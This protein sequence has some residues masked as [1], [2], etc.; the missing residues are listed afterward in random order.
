MKNF[1]NTY[2]FVFSAIMVILVAAVLSS[3]T[4]LL[5]PKQQ[6]NIEIEKKRK[7][8]ASIEVE[9]TTK[10]AEELYGKYIK[11]AYVVDINGERIEGVDAFGL[12]MKDEMRKPEEKRELPVY[13]GVLDEGK[14]EFIVPVRGTGLWGPI[15]G[16]VS[17]NDDF[18]TIFGTNFDHD[19]ETPGLGA[20]ITTQW[21]QDEFKGKKIF[22]EDGTFTSVKV[23]KG[24]VDPNSNNQVDAISG[25][26]LTSKGLENM[27]YDCLNLYQAYFKKQL[28]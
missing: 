1:S 27:L 10:N 24:K 7:I 8:L 21:F 4:I 6:K 15:F 9:S 22:S 14:K 18:N 2:I 5:Q 11:E 23:V 16:F 3:A 28:N 26:T 17:L 13:V 12:S 20:E 19:S 25:S